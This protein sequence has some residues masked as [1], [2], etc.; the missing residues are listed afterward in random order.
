MKKK[1]SRAIRCILLFVFGLLIGNYTD[2]LVGFITY[3]YGYKGVINYVSILEI[4]LVIAL[5]Q[6]WV[7]AENYFDKK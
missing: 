3:K 1:I 6:I 2:E 5:A 4:F 7:V